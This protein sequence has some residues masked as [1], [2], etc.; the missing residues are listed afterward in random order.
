MFSVCFLC[1]LGNVSLG[2]HLVYILLRGEAAPFDNQKKAEGQH[3]NTPGQGGKLYGIEF[4]VEKTDGSIAG[5]GTDFC[6]HQQTQKGANIAA[7][8]VKGDMSGRVFAGQI[9]IQ[10]VGVG[11]VQSN[12]KQI[13]HDAKRYIQIQVR[14]IHQKVQKLRGYPYQTAQTKG[15]DPRVAPKYAP[16]KGLSED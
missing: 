6:A 12:G 8:A 9:H 2:F 13:L 1:C 16:P 14:R 7:H 15:F 5:D 3:G 4:H 10:N 11:K